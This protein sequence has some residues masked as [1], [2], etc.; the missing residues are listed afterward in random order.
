MS[1][2]VWVIPGHHARRERWRNG[3]GWTREIV[4]WTLPA[5]MP[6][7]EDVPWDVRLSIAEV[8]ADG[9]FSTFAG[10]D[11]ELV[12]LAGNGMDLEVGDGLHVALDPP[13]GRHRFAGEQAVH[14]RLRD[15]RTLDFNLMWRRQACEATL[16]HRPLVGPMV[17]FGDPGSVWAL[18][19]MAGEARLG[20]PTLPVLR[21]GDTAVL[22][23]GDS[24]LRQVLDGAGETLVI[25]VV[26]RDSAGTAAASG[27]AEG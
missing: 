18:H 12:L 3:L 1:T 22:V 26:P 27:G 14:A 8:D 13:H 11:R 10:V 16:W 6:G 19:L 17:V 7:T 5:V 20:D 24:R 4:R 2:R 21:A 15:G 25:R 23:A 9:P